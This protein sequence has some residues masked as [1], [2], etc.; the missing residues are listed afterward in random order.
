MVELAWGLQPSAADGHPFCF[1]RSEGRSFESN[2]C[3]I[4]ASEFHVKV[5]LKR[6]SFALG[7]R[8]W[9]YLA[10]IWRRATADWPESYAILTIEAN[11]DMA[12]YQERQGAALLRRQRMDWLDH[13]VP[14]CDL[15]KPLPPRSFIARRLLTS[16]RSQPSLAL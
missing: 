8:N 1:V 15:L 7:D 11:D 14:E 3:L 5:A 2:R 16:E 13:L 10:G 6:F 4:P 9:F 12:P